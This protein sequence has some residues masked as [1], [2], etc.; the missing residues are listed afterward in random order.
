[1]TN[2]VTVNGSE[3]AIKTSMRW[4]FVVSVLLI[5]P[6]PQLAIDIYLPSLPVMVNALHTTKSLLQATLTI[7]I[8][9]L[10]IAQLVYGPCSDRFGR[11]PI[12]LIGSFI[13]FIS[14]IAAMFATTISQLLL[15]RAVQGIGMGCGFAVASA[16]LGDVYYGKRLAKMTTFSAMI[17][18]LSSIFAPLIGGYLQYYINWQANFFVMALYALIL[19]FCLYFFVF[20]TN[21]NLDNSENSI[22]FAKSSIKKYIDLMLNLKF[23]GNVICLTLVY[24]IMIVFNVLGP[25]IL[26]KNLQVDVVLYGKLLVIVGLAYFF[27]AMVNEQLLKRFKISAIIIAGLIII[28]ISSFIFWVTSIFQFFQVSTVIF[29]TCLSMLGVGLVFPNC[30]ANALDISAEKGIAGAFIG[31]AGLIGTSVISVI[32]IHLHIDY[33][34]VLAYIY[35]ALTILSAIAYI[36]T[37][38]KK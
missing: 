33:K 1:M 8:L 25:F 15:F 17:Y 4:F 30:F 6:L 9:F 12:L 28:A 23:L 21:Q 20:E 19:I 32:I 2:K 35:F 29:F 3:K 22:D 10:G 24:G 27:G 16:V 31:A 38:I 18:A 36:S 11:K 37:L 26:Q 7:Y 14:S 5:Y 13:F 34:Y